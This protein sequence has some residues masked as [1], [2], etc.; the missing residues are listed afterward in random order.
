MC[1]HAEDRD[2]SKWAV[3]FDGELTSRPGLFKAARSVKVKTSAR[4]EIDL[5]SGPN[6]QPLFWLARD[7]C[8]LCVTDQPDHRP[9]ADFFLVWN[10]PWDQRAQPTLIALSG[11]RHTALEWE[12]KPLACC[13]QTEWSNSALFI[14]MLTAVV[15]CP[16]CG[17]IWLSSWCNIHACACRQ[18][19][20]IHGT[21]SA[22]LGPFLHRVW[23]RRDSA[24]A[25]LLCI[26]TAQ[27]KSSAPTLEVE[28]PGHSLSRLVASAGGVLGRPEQGQEPGAA[29]RECCVLPQRAPVE[30]LLLHHCARGRL[31]RRRPAG[32]LSLSQALM[33]RSSR[34]AGCTLSSWG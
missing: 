18:S 34:L 31:P 32:S 6:V 23:L 11:Q 15:R 28:D 21:C 16:A 1:R 25:P 14:C 2:H 17:Q 27:L 12:V 13:G 26:Q 24:L 5:E 19:A 8:L 4:A 30:S 10:G 9:T 3:T 33:T 20:T 29:R 7:Q 22:C